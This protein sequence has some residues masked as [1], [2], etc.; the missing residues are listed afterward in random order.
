M[1]A[2]GLLLA[3]AVELERLGLRARV[4]EEAL[5]PVTLRVW[6]PQRQSRS[7]EV[8]ASPRVE[9]GFVFVLMSDDAL[10]LPVAVVPTDVPG[11]AARKLA[12]RMRAR[13]EAPQPLRS[14]NHPIRAAPSDP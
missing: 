4:V 2:R 13:S 14:R 7:A 3:L 12:D 11:V 6:E 9:G 8:V 1:R 5:R 10:G